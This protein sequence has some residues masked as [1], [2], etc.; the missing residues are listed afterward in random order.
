MAQ[1]AKKKFRISKSL[2][3]EIV[4]LVQQES[5]PTMSEVMEKT[6][7]DVDKAS[8]ILRMVKLK[9]KEIARNFPQIKVAAMHSCDVE[10]F[11]YLVEN[12]MYE[13]W[14]KCGMTIDT[15]SRLKSYN[16]SD[17]LRRFRYIMHKEVLNRRKSELQ[18]IYDLKLQAS[19]VNGE[20]FKISKESAISIFE[21]IS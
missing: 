18:L 14:I 15:E 2:K 7:N 19:I 8:F 17:P 9:R 3:K 4:A 6:N 20:W 1:R 13:G 12:E 21:N 11:I 10:G 16:G 5:S